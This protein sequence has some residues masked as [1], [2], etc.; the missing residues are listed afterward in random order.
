[1]TDWAS[2]FEQFEKEA[3]LALPKSIKEMYEH[4]GNGGFGPKYYVMG[5]V[6]GHTDDLGYT[7]L[8]LYKAYL[9]GDPENPDWIWPKE[10]IPLCHLGCAMYI[11]LDITKESVPIF[12]FDPNGYGPGSD[13]EF[14]DLFTLL[15]PSLQDWID[16]WESN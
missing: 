15:Y 7:V 3:K 5:L 9:Q 2:E 14:Q 16:S 10:L 8:D 6:S 11:C 4:F 13:R 12:K 1:M